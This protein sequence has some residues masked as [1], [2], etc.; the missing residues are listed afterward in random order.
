MQASVTGGTGML[1]TPVQ[2]SH[3]LLP[4]VGRLWG[5]AESAKRG[6]LKHHTGVRQASNGGRGMPSR[7]VGAF[8]GVRAAIGHLLPLVITESGI[9][10]G[11]AKHRA[12]L[13]VV[14]VG[15]S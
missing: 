11:R 4:G 7:E 10:N 9:G 1:V 2:R 5:H 14:C 3:H 12:V 13:I 6:D 8:A 15:C